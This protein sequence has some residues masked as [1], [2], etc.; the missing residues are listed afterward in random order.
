MKR[1]IFCR[2]SGLTAGSLFLPAPL[3]TFG[4]SPTDQ[5]VPSDETALGHNAHDCLVHHHHDGCVEFDLP[6]ITCRS[7]VVRL[8]RVGTRRPG[9]SALEQNYPESFEGEATIPFTLAEA[10][11]VDLRVYDEWGQRVATLVQEHLPVGSYQVVW[12]AE[13]LASGTYQYVLEAGSF[14][15]ARR[16]RVGAA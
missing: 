16:M 2:I 7:R 12:E 1:R 11:D 15:Q 8:E 13:D 4:A 9:S 5:A 10:G 14:L 6:P 3:L